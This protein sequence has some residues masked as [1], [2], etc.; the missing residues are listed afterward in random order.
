[1]RHRVSDQWFKSLKRGAGAAQA[2]VDFGVRQDG[3][4]DRKIEP[5]GYG[6]FQAPGSAVAGF[7]DVA[8]QRGHPREHGQ[9][10]GDNTGLV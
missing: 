1:M 7:P 2:D 5:L 4:A 3:R 10:V 9:A 6:P 8:A